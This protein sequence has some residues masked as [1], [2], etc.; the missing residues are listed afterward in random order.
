VL[1]LLKKFSVITIDGSKA[2]IVVIVNEGLGFFAVKLSGANGKEAFI[3]TENLQMFKSK[4]KNYDRE[5]S[6]G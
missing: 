4:K 2:E 5:N 3:K 1:K 6:T